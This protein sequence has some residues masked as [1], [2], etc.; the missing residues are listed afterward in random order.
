MSETIILNGVAIIQMLS[1]GAEKKLVSIARDNLFA[2]QLKSSWV[3]LCGDKYSPFCTNCTAFHQGSQQFSVSATWA[4]IMSFV[5]IINRIS[6]FVL[7]FLA[8]F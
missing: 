1:P 4:S 7:E 5:S 6:G 3:D 8:L 2:P